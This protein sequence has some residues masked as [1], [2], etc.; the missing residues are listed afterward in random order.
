MIRLL[1]FALLVLLGLVVFF[2]RDGAFRVAGYRPLQPIHASQ[3][4]EPASLDDRDAPRFLAER[5]AVEVEV[6][7]DM[8]LVDFLRLYQLEL[9]HVRRQIAEQEGV[10]AL[11]D[12]AVLLAGRRYRLSLTP[13][14]VGTP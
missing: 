12:G 3:I 8:P 14:E 10:A 2:W 9:P 13:A 6:P 1:S 11:D 4:D 7:R 5:N